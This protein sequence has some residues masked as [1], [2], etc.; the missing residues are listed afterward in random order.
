MGRLVGENSAGFAALIVRVVVCG[1]AGDGAVIGE[2]GFEVQVLADE[3]G[4][5][6][7]DAL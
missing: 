2:F 4:L 6:L 7:L 3:R 5:M 1:W